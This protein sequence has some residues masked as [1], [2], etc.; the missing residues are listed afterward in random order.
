VLESLK[1]L[2]RRE[3][4]PERQREEAEN[5]LRAQQELRQAEQPKSEDQRATEGIQSGFPF[6]RP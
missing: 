2:F 1:R 3:A 5:R 4:D 6:G